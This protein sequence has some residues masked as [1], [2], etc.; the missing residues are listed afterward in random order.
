MTAKYFGEDNLVE[1]SRITK[2]NWKLL[3]RLILD[4]GK[5]MCN[6]V[7]YYYYLGYVPLKLFF[8]AHAALRHIMLGG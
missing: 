7:I 1:C 3:F 4:G 8:A 2:V 5:N 6:D